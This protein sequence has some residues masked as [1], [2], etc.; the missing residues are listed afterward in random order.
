MLA[1]SGRPFVREAVSV[2]SVGMAAGATWLLWE[3][4]EP[5][6]TPLSSRRRGP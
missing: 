4:L 5:A 6:I 3:R 1:S 2:F